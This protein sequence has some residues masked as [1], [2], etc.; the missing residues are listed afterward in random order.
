MSVAGSRP[1]A[2]AEAW[3]RWGRVGALAAALLATSPAIGAEAASVT[4]THETTKDRSC[5]IRVYATRATA[6]TYGVAS[7][8]CETKRGVRHVSAGSVLYRDNGQVL[9]DTA[10]TGRGHLPFRLEASYSGSVQAAF[11]R[12]DFSV[13][14]RSPQTRR[15][16]R[17]RR[18][19]VPRDCAIGNTDRSRD[20]LICGVQTPVTAG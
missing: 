5:S 4:F 3:R 15:P 19:S 10:I 12:G 18:G 11:H 13:V 1:V 20:T 14:L 9:R 8:R 16:E 7:E 17:W 2:P 6:T